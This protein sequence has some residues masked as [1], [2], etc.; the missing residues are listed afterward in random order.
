VAFNFPDN[1]NDGDFYTPVAGLT[2]VFSNGAWQ[3]GAAA[4]LPPVP[5]TVYANNAAATAGGLMIG[6]FYRTGTNPDH[7]CV[8]H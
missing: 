7:V 1:P 3:Q 5:L 8:V 6:D 2:Y 4:S